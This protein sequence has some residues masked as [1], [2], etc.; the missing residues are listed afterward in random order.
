MHQ[1]DRM[2]VNAAIDRMSRCLF[3]MTNAW[4]FAWCKLTHKPY[5]VTA[6]ALGTERRECPQCGRIYWVH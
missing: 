1:T 2:A 3:R 5:V 4:R 6:S